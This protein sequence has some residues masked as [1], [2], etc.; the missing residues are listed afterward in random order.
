LFETFKS[1]NRGA[2]FKL[3]D[4]NEEPSACLAGSAKLRMCG[5]AVRELDFVERV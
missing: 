4:C 5:R 2:Q 3:R 1:F